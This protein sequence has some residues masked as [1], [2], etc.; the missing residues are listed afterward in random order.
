MRRLLTILTLILHF[1]IAS[2]VSTSN[3]TSS[4]HR[5]GWVS[6]PDG[7]GTFDIIWSSLFTIFLCTWTSLHLNVPALKETYWQ[8]CVRKFK[9]M[10]MAIMAPEFLVAFATGQKVEARRSVEMWK[11]SGFN[12]WTMRHGFYANMGGFILQPKDSQP[13][14][15]N[16]K[17]LHYL[18]T[19]NYVRYPQ[20]TAKE[21]WDKSKQDGFQKTL[22][23]LQ[24][25]WF[26]LQC[27]GRAIQHLPLT[28][29][30]LT[31]FSFVFCNFASYY[32]WSNKPLDVES[33]TILHCEASTKDIL[34]QAGN[35][36][37]AEKP[38]KQT[39]LDFIDNQS[40]SWLTEIQ[41]R[42][43]FRMGP[44][45][46][47]LPRFTNDRFP[48]IGAG[49]DSILLFIVILAY[50]CLHFIAWRFSFPTRVEKILWRAGCVAIVA[51]SF[52][53][54]ACET[55]QDGHRLG[56]WDRW[57]I[58]LFP[59]REGTLHRMSTMEKRMRER[60]FVPL[61]EVI[62]MSPVTMVYAL[63]R[64]YIVVEVFV[65]LRSLPNGAFDSVHWSDYIPHF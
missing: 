16:A 65:S 18:V 43:H 55:Y 20:I 27:L 50:C 49:P 56:R 28:T 7:R 40:P 30:E 2:A 39:P 26:V 58:K 6:Q 4:G 32:Q 17:Q 25:V 35:W 15:I 33:P 63:A 64:T 29:L 14:P 21:V 19:R 62:I 24:T 5:E 42:L 60:E 23:M 3:A 59:K 52:I 44:R 36:P 9:W 53:F 8:Q 37:D 48:V 12:D 45:E 41:P 46:R 1:A 57:Y 13:F 54:L 11:G 61:W 22:T 34:I 10:V 31:T 38:Y 47:P 51:T